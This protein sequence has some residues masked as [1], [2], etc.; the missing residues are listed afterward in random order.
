M[1]GTISILFFI[2]YFSN[3]VPI[4]IQLCFKF[5]NLRSN[6]EIKNQHSLLIYLFV[7]LFKQILLNMQFI[8]PKI[9]SSERKCLRGHLK[10][11]IQQRD[12]QFI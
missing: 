6:A 4:T 9:I 3:L 7:I 12:D 10:Y 1:Q 8:H 11:I 2:F 5:A